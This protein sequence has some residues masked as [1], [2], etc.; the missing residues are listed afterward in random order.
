MVPV[1]P[2]VHMS[3]KLVIRISEGKR[4]SAM[5]GQLV[6]FLHLQASSELG[7]EVIK[8]EYSLRLK[9]KR[10]DGCLPASNEIFDHL[11][12]IMQAFYA[13]ANY[14]FFCIGLTRERPLENGIYPIYAYSYAFN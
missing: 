3:P 2:S 10:N 1:R 4:Q 7:L 11:C 5:T 8:L 12:G 9:I 13:Y 14:H 6:L